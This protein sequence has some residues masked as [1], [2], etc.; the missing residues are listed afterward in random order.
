MSENKLAELAVELD[1]GGYLINHDQ[2]TPEVAEAIA[3]EEG[4]TP[5]T[6]E[7]WKALDFIAK[8]YEERGVVPGMRRMNKVGEFPRRTCIDSFLTDRSR[9]PLVSLAIPNP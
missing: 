5:L 7:H 3:I 1:E 2:W 6:D 9:K 4:I 8:D